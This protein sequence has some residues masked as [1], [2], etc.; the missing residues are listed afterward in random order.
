MK[1][2]YII[3]RFECVRCDFY[4]S[5]Y[6]FK[7]NERIHYTDHFIFGM[8]DLGDGKYKE[9]PY[10]DYMK[11]AWNDRLVPWIERKV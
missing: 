9:Y 6:L 1:S 11:L 4:D 2:C 7:D 10:G 5:F 3:K 8:A